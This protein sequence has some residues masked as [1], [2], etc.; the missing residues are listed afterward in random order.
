MHCT[1]IKKEIEVNKLLVFFNSDF[2]ILVVN[3]KEYGYISTS[4]NSHRS[5]KPQS[6][7]VTGHFSKY[8]EY[9]QDLNLTKSNYLLPT[10]LS[11]YDNLDGLHEIK[12]KK[13]LLRKIRSVIYTKIAENYVL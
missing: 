3:S 1:L 7:K 9:T 5:T 11:K 8:I 6:L 13:N 4:L 10:R 2:S 12:E